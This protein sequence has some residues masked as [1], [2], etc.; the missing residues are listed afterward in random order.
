LATP[1]FQSPPTL[2]Q[3][4]GY[5]QHKKHKLVPQTRANIFIC[6]L[7]HTYEAPLANIKMERQRWPEKQLILGRSGT[8]YVATVT[9]LLSSYCGAHLVESYC[10]EP[11]ISDTNWLRHLSSSYLIKIWLSVWRHQLANLHILK[12]WI[13]LEQKRYN[14]KV[15]NSICFLCRLL[16][17][18]LKWLRSERCNF[19]HSTTLIIN[20]SFTFYYSL[21]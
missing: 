2:F 3:S 19:R 12:T 5:F 10:K 14:L 21:Y 15:V 18:V 13:S 9:K 11:N 6:L 20:Y 16:F 17:C 7:D 8:Q 4:V 1:L